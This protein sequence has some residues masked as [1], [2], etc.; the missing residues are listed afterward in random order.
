M[1]LFKWAPLVLLIILG[2]L[3]LVR[4][5]F[6]NFGGTS[7]ITVAITRPWGNIGPE[8]EPLTVAT[9]LVSRLV[10]P[11]L[12][13]DDGAGL[14]WPGVA[15]EWSLNPDGK[16]AAFKIGEPRYFEDGSAVTAHSIKA[17]W[18]LLLR[19]LVRNGSD[20]SVLHEVS[21]SI[22]GVVPFLQ[23]KVGNVSGFEVAESRVLRLR[24]LNSVQKIPG[25]LTDCLLPVFS[26]ASDGRLLGSGDYRLEKSETERLRLA[27]LPKRKT[28]HFSWIEFV[29]LD[30]KASRQALIDRHVDLVSLA[31]GSLWSP[32][33]LT[34]TGLEMAT[35]LPS[36][37][38][39]A[40]LNS[41]PGRLLAYRPYRRVIEALFDQALAS[42][43]APSA[44]KRPLFQRD[45]QFFVDFSIGR[46][47]DLPQAKVD[48]SVLKDLV[49]ASQRH[50][51][52]VASYV[53]G[54]QWLLKHLS[55]AGLRL[56]ILDDWGI[57]RIRQDYSE[58]EVADLLL[59]FAGYPAVDLGAVRPFLDPS[60]SLFSRALGDVSK[61]Q[62]IFELIEQ[63]SPETDPK[64]AYQKLAR[65]LIEEA[66]ILQL[67]LVAEAT[68]YNPMR[69][70]FLQRSLDRNDAGVFSF[71]PA[72]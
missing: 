69:V 44:L 57:E 16:T 39:V 55:R 1:K 60:G 48:Q 47:S 27:G 23:G 62:Q 28:A 45:R 70:K 24:F 64:S 71:G 50:P 18:E 34:T 59:V 30:Q 35:G 67:G 21:R 17:S 31:D 26:V 49:K 9:G 8:F 19:R 13:N 56:E 6:K 12:V 7:G 15:T 66:K 33:D 10:F 61:F 4:R 36:R 52:K 41:R 37:R 54:G 14:Y 53:P 42:G 51:L 38:M 22:E 5:N 29:R 63:G 3:Y 20:H 43:D 2:G 65:N 32:A 68:V 46:L 11:C 58:G 72:E 40:T 25:Y